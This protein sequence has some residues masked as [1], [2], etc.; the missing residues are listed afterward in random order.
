M[1]RS[2]IVQLCVGKVQLPT[3]VHEL[4]NQCDNGNQQPTLQAVINTFLSL[5]ANS[6][7][8]YL[9][10][11]ALDECSEREKLMDV[12]S[13]IVK[14]SSLHVNLLAMSRKEQDILERLQ[15]MIDVQIDLQGDWIDTDIDLHVRKCL[16]SDKRL[17]K[18]NSLIKQEILEALIAGAH[19]M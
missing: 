11:D 1:L 14:N 18:W 19:G 5:L 3:Q 2:M 10:M 15:G 13:Q 4:Y 12:I 8:T 17:R 7:R 16:E 6:Q 9:I